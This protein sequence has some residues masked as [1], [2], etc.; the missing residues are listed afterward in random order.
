M[1]D[2]RTVSEVVRLHRRRDTRS[3][4]CK[5][6]AESNLAVVVLKVSSFVSSRIVNGSDGA[7]GADGIVAL[8]RYAYVGS[9]SS[10]RSLF[11]TSF[12]GYDSST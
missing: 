10:V 2:K 4:E 9:N 12:S 7:P 3:L 1:N 8:K 11:M 6:T 5:S